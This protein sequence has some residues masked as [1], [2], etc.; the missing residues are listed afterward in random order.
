[1]LC[2][3]WGDQGAR[4][5]YSIAEALAK[6][7][8]R[9]TI[10]ALVGWGFGRQPP[11]RGIR[12]IVQPKPLRALFSLEFLVEF[13]KKYKSLKWLSPLL[14]KINSLIL[15]YTLKNYHQHGKLMA[16]SWYTVA[17]TWSLGGRYVLEQDVLEAYVMNENWPGWAYKEFLKALSKPV[18]YLTISPY[19]E[20]LIYY[21]SRVFSKDQAPRIYFVSYF[22]RD[23]FMKGCGHEPPSRRPKVIG[24]I[25]RGSPHKA[26]GC[27][28]T[29]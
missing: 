26:S 28:Q 16:T 8:F 23:R 27:S 2:G 7:G 21:T 24:A 20:A 12:V 4:V 9:V 19:E 15:K 17:P 1:M 6:E 10:I 13:D 14:Y 11:L 18:T 22:V 25:A 29:L 3:V 5:I